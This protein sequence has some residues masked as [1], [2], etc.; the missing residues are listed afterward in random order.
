MYLNILCW[1]FFFHFHCLNEDC[2]LKF[3]RS[4]LLVFKIQLKAFKVVLSI[5]SQKFNSISKL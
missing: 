5:I 3:E 4:G 1:V 2:N